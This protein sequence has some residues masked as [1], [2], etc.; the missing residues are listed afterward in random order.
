MFPVNKMNNSFLDLVFLL[1]FPN[2]WQ[3]SIP[4]DCIFTPMSDEIE[5][6]VFSNWLS[7]MFSRMPDKTKFLL[8]YCSS[9]LR[10]C[11]SVTILFFKVPHFACSFSFLTCNFLI[12]I[13]FRLMISSFKL[14]ML[15]IIFSSSFT[16]ESWLEAL[17]FSETL[18]CNV[19]YCNH[20]AFQKI[21]ISK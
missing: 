12:T 20:V 2:E 16:N 15:L 11:F 1:V 10:F 19:L 21:K 7:S 5:A 6:T 17:L 3:A 13:S 8:S 9:G 14:L 18:S 4:S